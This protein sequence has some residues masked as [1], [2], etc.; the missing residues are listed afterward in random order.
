MLEKDFVT[1]DVLIIGS[2]IA[3][4]RAS[5][6]AKKY[7]ISVLITTKGWGAS[8]FIT[9]INAPLGHSDERDSPEV[10]YQDTLRGGV[11]LNN[12]QLVKVLASQAIPSIRELE[13]LGMEFDKENGRYAQRL[14]S[15]GTYPRAIHKKDR[16]GSEI[17]DLLGK[18]AK[19]QK[20]RILSPVMI[21]R[22]A[23]KGGKIIGAFGLDIK[24][25]RFLI[26]NAKAI[27][28]ATGGIGRLYEFT[29]YP[30]DITGQGVALAYRVGAELVDMEFIQFEPTAILHPKQCYGMLIPTAMFGDGGKL[31]NEDGERFMLNSKYGSETKAQKHELALVI[32][33]EVRE[34]RGT[35]H[36]GVYFNASTIANKTME[37]YPFHFQ[38]LLSAGFDL[39][40]D[41]VEV[42]P[43][44]HSSIGG[45]KIDEGCR[46]NIKGLFAGGEIVGGVH[47]ANRIAGN[48]ATE[49]I[50]FGKI[51]GESAGEYAIENSLQKISKDEIL[52]EEEHLRKMIDTADSNRLTPSTVRSKL[53]KEV[54]RAGGLVRSAKTLERGIDKVEQIKEKRA[55][56]L[57]ATNMRELIQCLEIDSMLMLA[58]AILKTAL[59]RCESR[60]AHYRD[61][62]PFLDDKRWLKNVLVKRRGDGSMGILA[63]N[64]S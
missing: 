63:C 33:K 41:S 2:G 23:K 50:V 62:F 55:K 16:A 59:I 37:T 21:V 35:K 30:N 51:A 54:S 61:D 4:L 10:Y 11:Y 57:K 24:N 15:G 31:V 40:R 13:T 27:I 45:V 25:G 26:I 42:G 6:A 47:G 44:A 18:E 43:A 64:I 1:T 29:T 9:A 32:A 28:L 22:I 12:K 19:R 8:P 53:Q 56:L 46:T 58:E 52:F 38:K 17:V 49:A 5:L 34:G 20:I 36:G 7:N 48:G 3:G 60:G 39:R 14:V